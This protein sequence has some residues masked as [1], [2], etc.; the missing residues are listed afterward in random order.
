M[1]AVATDDVA[2]VRA[3]ALFTDA[4]VVTVAL[5]VRPRTLVMVTVEATVSDRVR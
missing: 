5:R 1:A 4:E 3:A 2:S